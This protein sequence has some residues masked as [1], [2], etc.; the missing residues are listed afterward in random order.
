MRAVLGIRMHSEP[1]E[2]TGQVIGSLKWKVRRGVLPASGMAGS[3]RSL[4]LCVT[5][6]LWPRI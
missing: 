5:L 6:G 2:H 1:G 3:R 4:V